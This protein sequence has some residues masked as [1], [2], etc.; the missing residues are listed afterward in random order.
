MRGGIPSRPTLIP[1]ESL[2]IQG[3]SRI[4]LSSSPPSSF[5]L[6]FPLPRTENG[7]PQVYSSLAGNRQFWRIT[8]GDQGVP[9]DPGDLSGV[10]PPMGWGGSGGV[11]GGVGEVRRVSGGLGEGVPEGGP[12]TR[13]TYRAGGRGGVEG[14]AWPG[15]FPLPS[16]PPSPPRLYPGRG[17]RERECEC[18]RLSE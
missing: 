9:P 2:Y 10:P 11:G 3:P 16:L 8:G 17:L 14:G 5:L 7:R 18:E 6:L 1:R 4:F 13:V 15:A 12:P